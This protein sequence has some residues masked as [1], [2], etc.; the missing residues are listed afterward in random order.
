MPS[1]CGAAPTIGGI[2]GRG[3]LGELDPPLMA[4]WGDTAATRM[5]VRAGGAATSRGP[6]SP[7]R[8]RGVVPGGRG[9]VPEKG[10]AMNAP[11]P[12]RAAEEEGEGGV[13]LLLA[14]SM[15]SEGDSARLLAPV[16]RLDAEAEAEA[17]PP[18]MLPASPARGD[19]GGASLPL[20]VLVLA[21][22]GVD[23]SSLWLRPPMPGALL[24]D[25]ALKGWESAEGGEAQSGLL[26]SST[27]GKEGM[28]PR[29][30]LAEEPQELLDLEPVEVLIWCSCRLSSRLPRPPEPPPGFSENSWCRL[31]TRSML[32][33]LAS[34]AP[35]PLAAPRLPTMT[36]PRLFLWKEAAA[37]AAAK[38]FSWR[39]AEA[40]NGDEEP[41]CGCRG[42]ASAAAEMVAGGAW[43]A[44]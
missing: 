38:G 10:R 25:A 26:L 41:G 5:L 12:R 1:S 19:M 39:G 6:A 2:M 8:T 14:A 31:S 36:C 35:K 34:P 23:G 7:G 44:C 16:C 9:P 18:A 17:A 37:A 30:A 42:D 29:R 27:V 32:P 15:S 22:R 13:A 40:W 43:L 20:P 4:A 21:R 11:G 33:M 24:E 28:P 3:G